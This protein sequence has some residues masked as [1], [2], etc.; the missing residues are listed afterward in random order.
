MVVIG[1]FLLAYVFCIFL[2]FNNKRGRN[3]VQNRIE[4]PVL[5]SRL[6][7]FVMA[8][9]LVVLVVLIFTLDKMFPLNRPQ[10]F[11]LT[12]QMLDDQELTLTEKPENLENYKKQFVREYVRARNEIVPDL[13]V[14][15]AKWANTSDGI[16]RTWS[17][18]EV[19]G[20]FTETQMA[21]VINQDLDEAFDVT[22]NVEFPPDN[23]VI[24]TTNSND[25]DG[26]TYIVYFQY[27]CSYGPLGDQKYTQEYVLRVQ[28]Q[29]TADS[30]VKWADRM[31]NP[32]GIRVNSYDV[33]DAQKKVL[34]T[35][36][37]DWTGLIWE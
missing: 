18:D 21:N 27:K 5:V 25:D 9:S 30:A 36:P 16:V 13:G 26:D 23:S 7:T 19:F 15:R 32:L 14:M 37:L 29:S 24:K 1:D 35:D 3:P 34:N 17:T 20:R 4:P 10:V 33:I 12:S 8:T 31:E 6:M 11:F 28:L 22:C 2:Q